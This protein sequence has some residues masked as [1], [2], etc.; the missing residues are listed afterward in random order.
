ML[1]F[2]ALLP[3]HLTADDLAVGLT[4]FIIGLFKKVVLADSVAAFV[5][6]AF[7]SGLEPGLVAAWT[8]TWADALQLYFDFSG[9]SDMAVGL[10]RMFGVD[11]PLN[12]A[13]P[14]KATSIIEFWRRWHITLSRFLRDYLYIPLGGSRHGSGRRLGTC[15]PPCCW[16]PLAWRRLDV[17]ALGRPARRLPVRERFRRVAKT[18]LGLFRGDRTCLG[19]SSPAA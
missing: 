7:A 4:I 11:L 18:R 3:A 8:G 5:P 19:C 15:W 12:F 6:F 16:T 2:K 1:Q 9:Y 13:S 10:S 17:R 14:Y